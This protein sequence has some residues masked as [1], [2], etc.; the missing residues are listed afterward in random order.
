MPK[1]SNEFQRMVAMLT[2]LNSDGAAVHESVEVMEISSEERREVDVVAFGKVAGHR[3]AVF[4][5]CRDWKRP[6]DVQWVEQARTKFDDLGANVKIL[7]SSSGFTN[8]ALRKAAH[9]GIKTITTGEV[10]SEFVGRIVNSA[11]RAEYWHWVTQVTKAIAVIT[12]DGA[13]QQLEL[14][15]NVPVLYADG[16]EVSIFEALVDHVTNHHTRAHDQWEAPVSAGEEMYGK[17][18]AKYVV[19]CDGPEPRFNNQKVYIRGI[20]CVTGQEELFEIANVIVTFEA[21]LTVADVPLTHGEYDGTYFSTGQAPLGDSNAV[22]LVYTETPE[23][24]LDVI[25]RLDGPLD[26]VLGIHVDA[27]TG[28]PESVA[29]NR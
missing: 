28:K 4:I 5:E 25:G 22:Q 29:E 2:M 6:Q 19:T 27:S 18:K 3:S 9:Y 17:G 13:T 11:D 1:R 16:S 7:V 12:R 15:G 8:S 24:E 20:S 23:G 21:R 10:T 26:E 14:P